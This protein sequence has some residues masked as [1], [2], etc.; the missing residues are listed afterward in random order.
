MHDEPTAAL[1]VGEVNFDGLPGPT[2]NYAGLAPGNLAAMRN[3]SLTSNPRE[4]ALQGIAKMRALLERGWPQAVLPPHERPDMRTLRALGFDGRDADVLARAAREAPQLLAA[5]SS[6]A[7]MWT[8]NAATVSASRDTTDGRV[9]FTPAN[10]AHHLHRALETATT[11]RILRAAFADQ[12]RFVVHDALPA[13]PQLADEGAANHTR[14]TNSDGTRA[15]DLL[16]YGRV[17]FDPQAAHPVRHMARQTR[18]ASSAIVRRHGL[19][20]SRV[21]LAQQLPDA[22]DAGVFHNDVIAVGHRDVLL[23]HER[24]YIDQPSLIERLRDAVGAELEVIVVP[25]AEVKLDEAVAT[26]LFNS[27]LLSRRDGRLVMLA[28]TECTEHPRV[29]RYLDRLVHAQGRIAEVV[30]LD[31]RQS[32]RNGGGPAC[33]RLRVPLEA[34]ERAA[35]RGRLMLTPDLLDALEGWVLRHYRDRLAPRDLADVSLL[36]EARRA[37]DELTQMLSMPAIYAFQG[38]P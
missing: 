3:A 29:A 14:L 38:S 26:Y 35:M 18:E 11:T 33:L 31:L 36:E 20:P 28:P 25:E 2:H 12:T 27:Q 6:A 37:L 17:A 23:C 4:A 15:V 16:V 19:D 13:A 5:C 8:A 32:M 10:L 21:I 7:A 22:I 9:H 30:T 24:A 1:D 34:P